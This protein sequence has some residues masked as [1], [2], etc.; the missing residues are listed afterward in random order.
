MLTF[1]N[2]I[3]FPHVS[4]GGF[5]FNTIVNWF[6]DTAAESLVF[7]NAAFLMSVRAARSLFRF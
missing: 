4:A 7:E 3:G 5:G 1:E 2:G 6:K